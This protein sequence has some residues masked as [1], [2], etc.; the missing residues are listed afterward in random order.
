MERKSCERSS[1]FWKLAAPKKKKK[2]WLKVCTRLRSEG[3][4]FKYLHNYNIYYSAQRYKNAQMGRLSSTLN[5]RCN[6]LV[7]RVSIVTESILCD[8]LMYK[9][10]CYHAINTPDLCWPHDKTRRAARRNSAL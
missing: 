6:Y 2:K 5:N 9:E 7:A 8:M 1:D 4:H 3:F 10:T